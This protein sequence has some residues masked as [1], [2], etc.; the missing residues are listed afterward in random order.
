MNLTYLA[1]ALIPLDI[2]PPPGSTEC[3]YFLYGVD[4]GRWTYDLTVLRM[5][6]SRDLCVRMLES[7]KRDSLKIGWKGMKIRA[8]IRLLGPSSWQ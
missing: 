5:L 7:G 8:I 4:V 6:T 2:Q 3:P 1:I